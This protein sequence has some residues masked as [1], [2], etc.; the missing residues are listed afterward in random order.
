MLFPLKLTG[1][2]GWGTGDR[3]DRETRR[4]CNAWQIMTVYYLFVYGKQRGL[5]NSIGCVPLRVLYFLGRI[6]VF[7][8]LF[9][10]VN[11][12]HAS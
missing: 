12:M 7:T 3:R 2:H 5:I 8:S 9:L 10:S 6:G 11:Y 4:H 1:G